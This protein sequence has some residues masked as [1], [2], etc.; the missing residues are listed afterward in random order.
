MM[1]EEFQELTGFYPSEEMYKMIEAVYM[2]DGRD[3]REFCKAY[4][5]N[6]NGLAEKIARE[7]NRKAW[8]KSE[9]VNKYKE[10][11]GRAIEGLKER[12][13]IEEEWTKRP[14]DSNMKAEKYSDLLRSGATE[15]MTDAEAADYIFREFG[16]APATI[17]IVR[18]LDIYEVNRHRKLRKAGTEERIPLWCSTDWNYVRFNV[19]AFSYEVVNGELY[20]Y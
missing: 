9:A 14:C 20:K 8:E 3:K 2:S 4:K 19:R 7:V 11:M 1:I 17:K 12:L 13:E 16:F 6:E 10:A 18:E 15:K 5:E